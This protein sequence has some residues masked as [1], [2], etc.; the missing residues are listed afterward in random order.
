MIHIRKTNPV[1]H[2]KSSQL[3]IRILSMS[4]DSSNSNNVCFTNRPVL[5]NMRSDIQVVTFDA[6]C[7]HFNAVHSERCTNSIVI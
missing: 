4:K 7:T 2:T 5:Y 3:R 6:V 1:Q